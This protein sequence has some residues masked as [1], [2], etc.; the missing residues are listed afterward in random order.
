MTILYKNEQSGRSMVEM[1]GVLAIIGVLSIGG[2]SG[3]SKAMAKYRINKTLDQISTLVM[4]IRTLYASAVNYAGLTNGV[5]VQMGIIPRDMLTGARGSTVA[6]GIAIVNVYGGQIK[7]TASGADND[8]RNFYVTYSGLPME[9]CV[10]I[11]TA[12][13]GSQAGSGL[14]SIGIGASK[15]GKDESDS[16]TTHEIDTLPLSLSVAA[17]NCSGSGDNGNTIKWTY[18]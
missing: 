17:A 3:Y 15:S 14:Q 4:N 11:A 6:S 5:A 1:L 9:A 12:D 2:I 13:W 7:L 18:Y 8:N 10:S 16:L